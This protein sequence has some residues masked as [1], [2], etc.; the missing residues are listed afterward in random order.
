MQH[1][2]AVAAL[3]VG[4]QSGRSPGL[5][6]EAELIAVDTFHR[7]GRHG[8]VSDAYSIVKALDYLESRKVEIVNLSLAG[9]ANALL[10]RAVKSLT[11]K[12]VILVAAAGNDGPKAKPVYPAA[13]PDVVAV[14][15]VDRQ[16]RPYRRAARGPHID[17]AAPGVNVWI[18][19][20]VKGAKPRSGTSFA[21]PFV[22]AAIALAKKSDPV[23]EK[24]AALFRLTSAAE[25]LGEPGRDDIFGWGLLNPAGL[26]G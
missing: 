19:A 22:T 25:D 9:P 26:C 20:S 2:T 14:T 12:G 18:A 15:A 17:L 16:K 24:E 3:L 7:L 21:A 4:N 1:G 13:Y 6:P 5:L 8:D 11:D 10:E 23:S